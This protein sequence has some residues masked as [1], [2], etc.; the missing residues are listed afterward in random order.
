MFFFVHDLNSN[1]KIPIKPKS[2]IPPIDKLSQTHEI[3]PISSQRQS[4]DQTYPSKPR[5]SQS[6]RDSHKTTP[7]S[8][9]LIT[10][11]DIMSK[12]IVVAPITSTLVEVGNL[13]DKYETHH[14]IITDAEGYIAGVS[15]K[16]SLLQQKADKTTELTINASGLKPIYSTLPLTPVTQVAEMMLQ[17]KLDAVLVME[18]DFAVGIITLTNFLELIALKPDKIDITE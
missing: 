8:E 2:T 4:E 10:A 5:V 11:S 12:P 9:E 7:Y 14:I 13:M 15:T 3:K 6:D 17:Q 18:N 16:E 1:I